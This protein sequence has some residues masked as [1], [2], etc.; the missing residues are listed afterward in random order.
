VIAHSR[1]GPRQ[2]GRWRLR[3]RAWLQLA[4]SVALA[5]IAALYPAGSQTKSAAAD[6]SSAV[7]VSK[8]ISRS[9]LSGTPGNVTTTVVEQHKFSVTVSQTTGLKNLQDIDVSW[10]GAHPT[11]GI[12]SDP[13]AASA[14]QQEYPVVLLE[15]RGVDPSNPSS[16]P[17]AQLASQQTCWTHS[18]EPRLTTLSLP[19]PPWRVDAQAAPSDRNALVNRP[20]PAPA[21]CPDASQSEHWLPFVAVD[22]TPYGYGPGGCAGIPPE[23]FQ[24][25]S[26]STSVP[27]NATFA[28]SA[29]DGSGSSKFDVWSDEENASLGCSPTVVCTLEV[30]PILGI[31]CDPDGLAAD[32]PTPDIPT[33][34]NATAATTQCETGGLYPPGQVSSPS[35]ASALTVRGQLWWSA[36]NWN[37]R[38]SI[39]LSIAPEPTSCDG[40]SGGAPAY[41]YG[42]ELMSE[43]T[44]QWAPAFCSDPKLFK[45]THVITGEPL[46]TQL[47][48][49]GSVFAAFSSFAPPGGF[50]TPTVQ[51][52]VAVSGFAIGF[53]I[54]DAN[55][56]AVSTLRMTPRLLAK[57]LTESYQEQLCQSDRAGEFAYLG[58]NPSDI[59]QDPEFQALNPGIAQGFDSFGHSGLCP[60]ASTL[61]A[62][63]GNSDV[64]TAL[65]SYINADP[66]A[67]AWLDGTPDPWGMVVNKNYKNIALPVNQWPLLDTTIA[68]PGGVGQAAGDPCEYYNPVPWLASVASPTA[69]LALSTLA[70]QFANPPAKVICINSSGA[71][72]LA[73][74]WE[75]VPLG[76]QQP[77]NRFTIAVTSLGE[78]ARYDLN[79]A[80]LQTTATVADPTTKFSDTANR[81][82]TAP[83]T[84][85]LVAAAKL[86]TWD[87]SS[88]SWTLPYASLPHTPTAYPGTMIVNTDIPTSGLSSTLATDYSSLLTLAAGPLQT[89]GL[90]TGQLPP[91]YLPL[92]ADDGLGTQVAYTLRAAADVL[93]QAGV[94]TPLVAGGGAGAS[95]APPPADTGFAG[96]AIVPPVQASGGVDANTATSASPSGGS[97]SGAPAPR[98]SSVALAANPGRTPGVNVG[99][100]GSVLPVLFGLGVLGALT[101]AGSLLGPRGRRT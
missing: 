20:S 74:A 9:Y 19:F 94:V 85:A 78:A 66:E 57:L 63:D 65:T 80:Q 47:L 101:S 49:S 44:Q 60:G 45:L 36:S 27:P 64:T 7:T 24:V 99:S 56:N 30:I 73:T 41:V 11:G 95:G 52:P 16:V 82:F 75:L 79:T 53:N 37:N 2:F 70:V 17:A 83:T 4:L 61:I 34:T 6:T 14:D 87:P 43:A 86:F 93:N 31:S 38:I 5:L 98:T 12:Q 39:P 51:A 28:A 92:T 48:N 89:V 40:D 71:M 68:D 77:G 62:L 81:V 72:Q 90:D 23:D 8:T 22:G 96:G 10:S 55:G 13:N 50:A 33:G 15:C 67:R 35:R 42:S 25:D 46:A 26:S 97:P 3:R 54:D 1:R 88:S 91:G 32:V 69:T 76:R 100:L 59:T 18:I 21:A 29:A 58:N 84:S